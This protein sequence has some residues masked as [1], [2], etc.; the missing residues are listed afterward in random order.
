VNPP[1]ELRAGPF[2]DEYGRQPALAWAAPGRVNLIGEHIDYNV[3]FVLPSRCHRGTIHSGFFEA[4]V[5]FGECEL[6]GG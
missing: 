5:H 3:G 6:R 2:A 4:R 1:A